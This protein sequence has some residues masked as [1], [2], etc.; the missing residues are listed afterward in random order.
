MLKIRRILLPLRDTQH[1]DRV[2]LRKAAVL[3]R[4]T[5]ASIELFHVMEPS[6][7]AKRSAAAP[8]SERKRASAIRPRASADQPL[9][10]ARQ[11]LERVARSSTWA[12]GCRIVCS[13]VVSDSP[14][15]AIVRRARALPADLVVAPSQSHGRAARLFLRNT[16]RELIRD[17]SCP[18]LLA[19]SRRVYRKPVILVSVDPFHAHSKPARLDAQLLAAGKDLARILSGSLHLFHA[20]MPLPAYIEG[21]LGEPV[22]WENPQIEDVHGAQVRRVFDRLAQRAG[23]PPARRH[24]VMGDVASELATSVRQAHAAVVVMGEVSRPVLQRI[25]FGS[26][27]ERVLDRLACDVLTLNPRRRSTSASR[28]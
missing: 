5:G 8:R 20:Y 18:L 28:T 7:A 17:C 1:I 12:R 9:A 3:A 15:Q 25:F 2:A 10:L 24:L 14:A 22:L 19:K 23:I 11:R 21:A 27:A 13:V 26:T 16:D 4:A 6:S